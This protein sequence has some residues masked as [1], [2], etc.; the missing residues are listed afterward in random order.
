MSKN[1]IR[2][3]Y[4]MRGEIKPNP[5]LH[6]GIS[7]EFRPVRSVD[8]LS[9]DAKLIKAT[10][11]QRVVLLATM[12]SES[13]QSWSETQEDGQP[14]PITPQTVSCLPFSLFDRLCG[15]V[16]MLEP[17]DAVPENQDERAELSRL[18]EGISPE[19]DLRGN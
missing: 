3:G 7:F 11:E 13:L 4:T 18:L 2:D 17:S 12:L 8:V 9:L 14:W 19:A 15:I 16:R 5:G 6:D 1:L 10:P